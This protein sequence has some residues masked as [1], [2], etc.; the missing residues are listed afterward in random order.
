MK[1]WFLILLC[2]V[3]GKAEDSIPRIQDLPHNVYQQRRLNPN[4]G[5]FQ[6]SS[7]AYKNNNGISLKIAGAVQ[8]IGGA[9]ATFCVIKDV[10]EKV[11]TQTAHE[12]LTP[13][14]INGQPVV[15][16]HTYYST[17]YVGKDWNKWHTIG[18]S[19]SV[20]SIVSGIILIIQ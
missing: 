19:L 14:T 7:R 2:F 10:S 8:L 16:H 9:V 4:A 6:N 11:P 20:S 3:I 5:V 18:I 15:Y 12:E 17:D 13:G 1:L